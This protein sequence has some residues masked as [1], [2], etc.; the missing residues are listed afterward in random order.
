VAFVASSINP[1][2]ISV[3]QTGDIVSTYAEVLSV[4]SAAL[5]TV[6]TYTI[7][8]GQ[9]F[10][11]QLV[12]FNGSNIA[13]YT[14]E[15]DA[16]VEGKKYTYWSGP[17]FGEFVFTQSENKGLLLSASQVVRLRVIHDRLET[18]DFNGRILGILI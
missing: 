17:M 2:S 12:E 16:V 14:M 8:I 5:T 10:N 6:V 7:P 18:G 9:T 1:K 4:A 11:L 15:V 3:A 13:T